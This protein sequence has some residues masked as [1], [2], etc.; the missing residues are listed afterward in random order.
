MRLH[1]EAKPPLHLSRTTGSQKSPRRVS[2][3]WHAHSSSCESFFQDAIVVWLVGH[4]FAVLTAVVRSKREPVG[5]PWRS[6]I[7][8]FLLLLGIYEINGEFL[9]IADA[10]PNLRSAVGLLRNGSFS[11]KPL[12]D[13]GVFNWDLRTASGVRRVRVT[14]WQQRIDGEP[15]VNLYQR[16]SLAPSAVQ[17][18]FI[19]PTRR[20]DEFVGIY[21]PGAGL[22]A[23]PLFGAG[24]LLGVDVEESPRFLWQGGKSVAAAL[25]AGS[26]VLIYWI[27][28][29]ITMPKRALLVALSYGLGTSL[30][31]MTSQ[32]LWQQAPTVF[33]VSLSVLLLAHANHHPVLITAAGFATGMAAV[34]RP[35]AA[36]LLLAFGMYFDKGWRKLLR[37]VLGAAG[38]LMLLAF[39]NFWFFGNPLSFGQTQTAIGVALA[40]TGV[41]LVWQTPLWVGLPGLLVSPSRGLLVYSP[42]LIFALWG[43]VA[44]WRSPHVWLR[45]VGVSFFALLFISAR[46]FDWAGG[47]SFGYRILADLLPLLIVMLLTVVDRIYTDRRMLASYGV[48]LSISIAV[49][50]L[51]VVAYDV[52][53]WDARREYEVQVLGSTEFLR[54]QDQTEL[55]A[56]LRNHPGRLVREITLDIDTP[57]SRK[58]LWSLSDNPI[59]YYLTHFSEARRR[60]QAAIQALI[61]PANR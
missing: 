16:G 17:P 4:G 35:T 1:P 58:R 52:G 49:Q 9:P 10:L 60:K 47:H 11:F 3:E 61:G 30:W 8:L 24:K 2:S 7:L 23:A 21:G 37:F 51:G 26:A 48:L 32:S 6:S 19:V 41:P 18:Y 53:G 33:L 45:P 46:W 43:A 44:A 27:G 59:S 39:Y 12:N 55:D 15:A 5:R 36:I 34:C 22:A 42:F 38:P 50:F 14:H 31:S 20:P 54:A 56:L 40:K 28:L 25:V 29:G 57:M 13:P